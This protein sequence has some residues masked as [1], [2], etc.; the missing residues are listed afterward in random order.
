ME[1]SLNFV[2]ATDLM[3]KL[4]NHVSNQKEDMEV[5][6]KLLDADVAE[7]QLVRGYVKKM[8]NAN[9]DKRLLLEKE[10]NET[11]QKFLLKKGEKEE[12]KLNIDKTIKEMTSFFNGLM[13]EKAPN[14]E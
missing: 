11:Y 5:L 10:F 13:Q 8:M 14:A 12:S 4:E 2:A 9:P 3:T 1:N 6:Q 7:L